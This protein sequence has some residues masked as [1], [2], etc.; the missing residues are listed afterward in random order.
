MS[1]PVKSLWLFGYGSLLW[2]PGFP[3]QR[4]VRGFVPGY[5]RRFWQGSIDHRGSPQAPGRVVTL[6]SAKDEVCWGVAY[7]VDEDVV[8]R[9][10]AELDAREQAGYERMTVPFE[11]KDR[12]ATGAL[13]VVLYFAPP[14][15]PNYLGEAPL[16][17]I[18]EQ[19]R[20]SSGP[21]GHNVEYVLRLA[22]ALD[23]LGVSDSHVFE[24]ANLLSDPEAD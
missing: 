3:Y 10:V 16:P 4:R 19:I 20:A 7:Q 9:T 24:L 23:D 2:R 1:R 8:E 11:A 17:E 6:T 15:N 12:T 21:S 13:P 14:G 5:A 18:A 22:E